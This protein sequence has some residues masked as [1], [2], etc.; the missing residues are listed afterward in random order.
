MNALTI[1]STTIARD[2]NGRFGLS[3]LHR[4]AGGE[5][6]HSP[7][8]W[9]RTAEFQGLVEELT[10]ELAFAPA[11]SVRGGAQPGTYVVKELV[12]AYAM[13]ISA[14]FSLKVIRAYDAMVTA[15]PVDP[16]V[17]LNDPATMRGLLLSYSDKV[18]RLEGKVAEQAPKVEALELLTESDGS[19]CLTD[20]GKVLEMPRDKFIRWLHAEGWIYRRQGNGQWTAHAD[21]E[22]SG[23]LRVKMTAYVNSKTDETEYS[24]N[25]RVTPKGLAKLAQMAPQRQQAA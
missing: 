12:Y 25:V 19:L 21:K 1:G 18:L 7:N 16:M 8:R 4:A 23:Y 13:W 24:H 20:A 9:T 14:A 22:K 11:E 15:K 2:E 3:D 10:P 5:E 6:K 17:A